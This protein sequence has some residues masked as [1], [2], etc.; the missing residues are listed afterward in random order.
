MHVCKKIQ[1][2]DHQHLESSY[3]GSYL[4]NCRFHS[5]PNSDVRISNASGVAGSDIW[6]AVQAL[7]CDV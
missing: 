4:T 3:F 2:K 6:A 5:R 1:F 7:R